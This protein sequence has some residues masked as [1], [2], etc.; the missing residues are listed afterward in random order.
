MKY[1]TLFVLAGCCLFAQT[2]KTSL[3]P[4]A[5]LNAIA[6]EASG[7]LAKDTVVAIGR[8]HRVH[9]SAGFHEAAEYVAAKAREFGLQDVHIE[10]FPADGKTTYNTFRSYLGWDAS[11]GVL[12]EVTPRREVIADYAKMR[13]ALADYSNDADVTAE[14]V[15]VGSGTSAKDYDGK[16]VKGRIVLAGGGV[17]EAHHQ[18]VE[19]R[20]AAGILSYQS[21]Q[22]TGWSGDYPDLVRWGHLSPYNTGNTFAFMISLRRAREFQGRLAKGEKIRLHAQVAARMKPGNFEVVTGVIRGTDPEA[23]EI[24]FSCHLCHEKAGANDD[25]S[26]AAAILE[27]AR[28]LAKLITEGKLP[29][30]RRTIRFIWPPEIAGTMCYLARHGDEIAKM[31]A[32]IHMDMVGGDPRTTKA[33]LHLT[34]TPA[35]LPSFVNDVAA[36]FGDYVF[37]GARRAA[38]EG[39]FSNANVSPEGS[40]DMLLADY[41]EFTMGSDH[42][43]YEEGS[44]RVPT[45]YMNDWPDVFI[46]T[47]Q[48]VPENI[49][50]TKMQRV[51][52]IG[53]ASGYF[54]A[55]AGAADAKKLAGEVFARGAAR[56]GAAL[57]HAFSESSLPDAYNLIWQAA[58]QERIALTS[59]VRLEPGLKPLLDDLGARVTAREIGEIEVLGGVRGPFVKKPD[60]FARYVVTRNPEVVGNLG[61]YYYDYLRDRLPAETPKLNG[62]FAY[63]ALNV[64]DGERNVADIRNVLVAAY[65]TVSSADLLEYFKL[66]EKAGVVTVRQR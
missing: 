9:A 7:S 17:A 28:L 40:K 25:A 13:V 65:G 47:N 44:F 15:D 26:G 45:I 16:D 24:V 64:V 11:S 52:V 20:G 30:P 1:S 61:V 8:F 63:E 50:A 5:Q 10:L 21:N 29:R 51:V 60:A 66:L 46:H 54:M 23:G 35:S 14:L 39:D 22:V 49:D 3:L 31:V 56:Q 18:A 36:V 57:S 27:D 55:N 48:D 42:D 59:I 2:P 32:A 41:H 38:M 58:L 37:D 6:A 43:V 12:T 33:I 53:A 62:T 4:D 34:R 19:L